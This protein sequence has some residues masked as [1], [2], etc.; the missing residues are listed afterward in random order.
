VYPPKDKAWFHRGCGHSWGGP[1]V[2]GVGPESPWPKVHFYWHFIQKFSP[3][4]KKISIILGI[5]FNCY[6][7]D[8]H[9]SQVWANHKLKW[10]M[11]RFAAIFLEAWASLC[12]SRL[13]L[14]H[15][16]EQI[17]TVRQ[18]ALTHP[19]DPPPTPPS[20][21]GGRVEEEPWSDW[22]NKG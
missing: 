13:R 1:A 10:G 19:L 22:P 8:S 11:S 2:W 12:V 21:W 20:Q 18:S 5:R 6:G 4:K 7:L 3:L 15:V 9:L 14:C 16:M 17:I